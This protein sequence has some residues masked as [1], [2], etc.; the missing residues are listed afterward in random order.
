MPWEYIV[1]N[2]VKLVVRVNESLTVLDF[3]TKSLKE[4]IIHCN[5]L[6]HM[7]FITSQI[8]K[9]AVIYNCRTTGS[10][11]WLLSMDI[12]VLG[13]LLERLERT[14]MALQIDGL[15]TRRS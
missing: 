2:Q 1:N 13:K 12:G 11:N 6:S 3:S 4:W 14:P 8:G 9:L 15:Q 5:G 10:K 7:N